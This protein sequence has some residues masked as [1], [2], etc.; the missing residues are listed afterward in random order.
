ML[1]I[2]SLDFELTEE[3][4]EGMLMNIP[5]HEA[6]DGIQFAMLIGAILGGE[7]GEGKEYMNHLAS[8]A[9]SDEPEVEI[10]FE[11]M[12]AIGDAKR[13]IMSEAPKDDDHG[14]HQQNDPVHG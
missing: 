7:K 14:R 6:R 9:Y 5:S 11:E 13:G 1:G 8:I 2:E 10:K 12:F 4:M 3:D